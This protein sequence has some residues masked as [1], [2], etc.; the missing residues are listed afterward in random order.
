MITRKDVLT[1]LNSTPASFESSYSFDGG[2]IIQ[3]AKTAQIVKNNC[4]NFSHYEP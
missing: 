3:L 1:N 4:L 2:L